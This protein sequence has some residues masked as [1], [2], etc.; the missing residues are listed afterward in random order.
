[1]ADPSRELLPKP[2]LSIPR[3][4][5][6]GPDLYGAAF[7]QNQQFAKSGP[8]QTKLLPSQEALFRQ[9]VDRHRV[10]FDPNAHTS[11]YDMR[12]YWLSTKGAPH[13]EGTHFPDTF[14]TPY[15]TSFS[16]E[17]RYALPNAPFKWVGNTLYDVRNGQAIFRG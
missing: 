13:A 12:A 17:S 10:P 9:W 16:G 8:Y 7:A 6:E 2:G 5:H 11:D 4:T 1:M 15:D 3:F 14:K